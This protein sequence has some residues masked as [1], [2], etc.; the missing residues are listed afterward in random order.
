[1]RV[2]KTRLAEAIREGIRRKFME[3]MSMPGK[4]FWIQ[5]DDLEAS[6]LKV[7][8]RGVAQPNLPGGPD[9]GPEFTILKIKS[10]D[11]EL[12]VD[13]LT[14]KENLR[15]MAIGEDPV[16]D[17]DIVNHIENLARNSSL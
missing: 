11:G 17:A 1:M 2:T 16:S 4:T 8:I 5:V 10:N 6:P 9:V 15:R 13:Q 14:D 12:S 3:N 7:Q